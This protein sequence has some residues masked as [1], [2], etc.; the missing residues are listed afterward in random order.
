MTDEFRTIR[1]ASRSELEALMTAHHDPYEAFRH[2]EALVARRSY[3][4]AAKHLETLAANEEFRTAAVLELLG[5]A[6]FHAAQLEKS[7]ATARELLDKEPTNEYAAL[8]LARSL[9]R[10]GRRDEAAKLRRYTEALS[11]EL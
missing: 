5:R 7:V 10:T 6:Y 11:G 9:E 1:M 4:E 2:A 8:L 3:A